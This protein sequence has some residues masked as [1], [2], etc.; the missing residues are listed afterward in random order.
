MSDH[1]SRG[2]RAGLAILAG[3]LALSAGLGALGLATGF[4]D[5]GR[6]LTARLPLHSPV[7][8]SIALMV[9]VA[10]PCAVLAWLAGRG[11][12][13]NAR[14]S[15]RPARIR[16]ASRW[17]RNPTAAPSH[18]D[19]E[20]DDIADEVGERPGRSGVGRRIRRSSTAIP[21]W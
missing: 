3:L 20:R 18:H 16:P 2:S 11:D 1:T 13:P 19:R 10:L 4:L 14:I 12:Q 15:S 7:L 6:Q 9:V 17:R 5:L 8:G 21:A